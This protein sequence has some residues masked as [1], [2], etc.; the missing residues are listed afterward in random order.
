MTPRLYILC[1]LSFA[2]KS[3][4]ARGIA[5]P[6]NATIVE[7]DEYIDVVRPNQLNKLQEWRLIQNLARA[8]T[9]ELLEAGKSVIYDDLMV[10]PINRAELIQL[11]HQCG[12]TA[13]TI[14]LNTSAE[15]VRQRQQEKSPTEERQAVWDNHTQLLLSQ[16]IPPPKEEAIYLEPGY[17]LD[18]A[19]AE[20]ARR[21]P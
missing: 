17:T 19:L 3:T 8:R 6:L 10:E 13:L 20:I 12:A 7:C 14:F 2:G 5:E 1:G 11:A 4:L 15:T 21:N 9:K 16:L 18:E